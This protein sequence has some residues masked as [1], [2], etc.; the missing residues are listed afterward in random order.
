MAEVMSPVS[1]E[2]KENRDFNIQMADKIRLVNSSES[3]DNLIED[4]I[5]S[6]EETPG[7]VMPE[8]YK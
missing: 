2:E 3:V 4:Y 7:F 8:V 5:K 6:G 1:N